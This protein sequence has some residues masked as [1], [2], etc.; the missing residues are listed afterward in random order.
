M[1][2]ALIVSADTSLHEGIPANLGDAFLTEALAAALHFHGYESRSA[3][4]GA[5]SFAKSSLRLPL[6]GM[7]VSG[8]S[9]AIRAS[10][11]VLVGGGTLLQDDTPDGSAFGGLARLLA[12]TSALAR[13]H[14]RPLAYFGVGAN[15]VTRRPQR[16]LIRVALAGRPV[17]SRDQW[18]AGL[19]RSSYGK[20]S[21]IAADTAM[22]ATLSLM[23]TSET[24][25]AVLLAG[26]PADAAS[27]DL[28]T[29][30]ALAKRYDRVEFLSM[31]QGRKSDSSFLHDDVRARLDACHEN[32][33]VEQAVKVVRRSSTVISSRMHA[34]YLGLLNGRR[35]TALG[36]RHKV[37]SF[38]TEFCVPSISRWSDALDTTPTLGDVDAVAAA[39]DRVNDQL[40]TYLTQLR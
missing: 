10:D 34:L 31:S 37:R 7:R 30:A 32:L 14:S 25:N 5:S 18:T 1:K 8:L 33:S 12:V 40:H 13:L 23:D 4:F 11:V 9:R 38:G 35:L 19:L 2:H 26:Y 36:N 17:Y 3:D 21:V 27:L 29:V 16:A 6:A 20:H 15:P 28:P 22:L 24:P 39:Q